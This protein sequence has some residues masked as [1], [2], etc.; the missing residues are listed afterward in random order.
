MTKNVLHTANVKMVHVTVDLMDGAEHFVKLRAA[1]DG[2]KT[3]LDT[4]IVFHLL[5][6][7]YVDLDG[8]E[9]DVKYQCVL[10]VEIVAIVVCVMVSIMIP[11]SVSVAMLDIWD[12]DVSLDV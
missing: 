12:V 8:V 7:V 3:A 5:V 9:E 4:E 2:E 6:N 10:V 1:Q 11:R